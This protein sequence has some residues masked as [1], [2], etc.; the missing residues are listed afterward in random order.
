MILILKRFSILL[1]GAEVRNKNRNE[2]EKQVGL[3][4]TAMDSQL[5]EVFLLGWMCA[6][7]LVYL[8]HPGPTGG[9]KTVS[10]P[11]DLQLHVL[12]SLLLW[13]LGLEPGLP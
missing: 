3:E 10:Q 9:Q 7:L 12:V 11:L 8:M 13:V 6:C 4:G 2:L 5:T 1:S